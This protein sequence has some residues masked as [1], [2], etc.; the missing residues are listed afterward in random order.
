MGLGRQPHGTR[1]NNSDVLRTFSGTDTYGMPSFVCYQTR[2]D[3]WTEQAK[4]ENTPQ[5][6]TD[7]SLQDTEANT[8]KIQTLCLTRHC[9]PS[10][11]FL[12]VGD[13]GVVENHVSVAA[14]TVTNIWP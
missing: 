3:I 1:V 5:A 4:P 8:C 12:R 9:G 14:E 6:F 7:H 10:D 11:W 2:A 13:V